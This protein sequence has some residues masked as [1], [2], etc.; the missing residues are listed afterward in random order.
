MDVIGH[1]ENVV[2]RPGNGFHLNFIEILRTSAARD[3]Q[4]VG[5]AILPALPVQFASDG[6][7]QQ[8][9]NGRVTDMHNK[10]VA[11]AVDQ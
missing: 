7:K 1:Q 4:I 8:G 11:Y 2:H 10:L 6:L 3:G 9:C 5:P